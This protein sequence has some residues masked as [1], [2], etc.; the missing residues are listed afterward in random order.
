MS[1]LARGALKSPTSPNNSAWPVPPIPW[2]A[3]LRLC[4][5]RIDRWVAEAR[6]VTDHRP[7]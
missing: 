6:G 2:T 4:R 3:I 1:R 5:D 7:T